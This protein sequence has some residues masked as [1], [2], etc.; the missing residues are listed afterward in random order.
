MR[1]S[2]LPFLTLIMGL[3]ANPSASLAQTACPVGT[4]AGSAT[5]GPSSADEI[6]APPR[7]T[8]EWI[9]TWGAIATSPSGNGGVSSGR[10]SKKEAEDV[11]FKNCQSAGAQSCKVEFVYHNQCVA[12]AHPVGASGAAF[13][14]AATV[15]DAVA[16]A[17][18]QCSGLGKGECQIAI[19]ECSEPIF[20]KY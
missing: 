16:R 17:K 6:S 15:S 13:S 8:G 11:A 4:A 10:A 12:L 1:L 20:R 2:N 7:P 19:A 5:C 18:S 3:A 14:T 9:K